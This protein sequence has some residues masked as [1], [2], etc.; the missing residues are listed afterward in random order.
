MAHQGF[1]GELQ[2]ILTKASV[3]HDF[4]EGLLNEPRATLERTFGRSLPPNLRI[5]FVTK[6]PDCDV[7][8]VLPDLL[9]GCDE[10]SHDELDAVSGGKIADPTTG[11]N[12]WGWADPPPTP[13]APPTK[14]D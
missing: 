4:R 7:M 5:K 8:F 12:I 1:N 11:S 6:D 2:E 10:L 13:P 9:A 14:P 3:D